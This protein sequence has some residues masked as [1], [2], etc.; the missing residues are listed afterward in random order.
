VDAQQC[1]WPAEAGSTLLH[2]LALQCMIQCCSC[3][4]TTCKLSD[5]S[6]FHIGVYSLFAVTSGVV[7]VIGEKPA[8]WP[9]TNTRS[10]KRTAA[11]A[12]AAGNTH[13][14]FQLRRGVM[15]W[16]AV[17]QFTQQLI[18]MAVLLVTAH[19]CKFAATAVP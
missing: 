14:I 3:S 11:A 1:G 12:A 7:K 10:Y 9:S 15:C 18:Q 13:I 16:D 4:P 5:K 19:R 17:S 2:A 6:N 8:S